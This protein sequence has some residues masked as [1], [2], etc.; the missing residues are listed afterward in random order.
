MKSE[1]DKGILEITKAEQ[2]RTVNELLEKSRSN[3]NY[4]TLLVL[5]SLIIAAGLILDSSA[6]IIGGML[7]TPV[8][9]PVLALALGI[10]ASQISF[11][12]RDLILLGK[13]FLIILASA[14]LVAV[15]FG[16]KGDSSFF[17]N[18]FKTATLYFLVALVSGIAATFA[19]TKKELSEVLPGIAIS[20][21]LV[22]PLSLVGIALS[23]AD[24]E[25]ARFYFFVFLF[26]FIGIAM[27]SLTVFS[28]LKFHRTEKKINRE[29]KKSL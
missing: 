5:S 12:K 29:V 1:K 26:N 14:F 23:L 18:T 19:W 7:V 22:P 17:T 3:A 25:S 8:L 9:T 6:V 28:L 21:A 20:V 11:L 4:Y 2:Y 10:S 15:I 16:A 24:F 13:S 27:G